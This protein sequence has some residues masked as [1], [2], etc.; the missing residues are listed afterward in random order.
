MDQYPEING[1][2]TFSCSQEF[3]MKSLTSHFY[4]KIVEIGKDFALS[5]RKPILCM[6]RKTFFCGTDEFSMHSLR[7]V[8]TWPLVNSMHMPLLI[9]T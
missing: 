3:Y 4:T 2:P 9:G 7:N 6:A 5:M 1:H 8:M